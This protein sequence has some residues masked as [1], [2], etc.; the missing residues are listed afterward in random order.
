MPGCWAGNAIRYRGARSE[1]SI[2]MI[3][4]YF[5]SK[6][7]SA[8]KDLEI[9]DELL[10]WYPWIPDLKNKNTYLFLQQEWGAN[11]YP[12]L[13]PDGYDYYITSGDSLMFGLPEYMVTKLSGQV[14]QLTGCMMPDNVDGKNFRYVTHNTA[15]KRVNRYRRLDNFTKNI[16]YKASALGTR[17]TQSKAIVFAALMHYLGQENCAIG[18]P[19]DTI[20]AKNVHHWQNTSNPVC[21]HFL[22]MFFEQHAGKKY[23]LADDDLNLHGYNNS[24]YRQSALNFTQESYHYSFTAT[25]KGNF[26]Q[27]GP[28]ITEKTWKCIISSTAFISVGQC[29]VYRWLKSLGLEFDY[30]PLNLDFDEDPGNLTRLEKIVAL[31]ESL[32]AWSAADLYEMTRESTQHNSEYVQSK[33][34]WQRCEDSNAETYKL[35]T[36]LA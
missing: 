6:V 15:H 35:L 24:A 16:S 12:T 33:E 22:K 8:V 5:P 30:G 31:I 14:V 28:F 27:P 34:F 1:L 13:P 9:T 20:E 21:D 3:Y 18:L 11:G 23:F 4:P 29:Y 32:Q 25:E 2:F 7:N 19:N 10:Y 17:V 26:I 36:N